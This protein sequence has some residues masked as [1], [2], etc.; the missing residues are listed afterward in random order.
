MRNPP[1]AHK[2]A[3]N[4]CTSYP[5]LFC[6]VDTESFVSSLTPTL[7]IHRFRLGVAI[8]A[9]FR[10]DSSPAHLEILHF[11]D[12][13]AFWD[14]V[15][16]FL[17][18]KNTLHIV[19]HNIHYDMVQ[20]KWRENLSEL[21]FECEFVFQEALTFISKWKKDERR[22]MLINNT[23]WFPGKLSLWGDNLKIE[24]LPMP[25][26][27]ESDEKWFVY[28]ERDAQI[29]YELQ[30]WLCE[31]IVSNNLGNWKYT[32]ASLSFNAYRHRF[33]LHPIY[34][35]HNDEEVKIA[36][37]SYHGGRVE[38]LFAGK[39]PEQVYYK[40]D[41]NSMYPYV[42]SK[43]L[44][45]VNAE[46]MIDKINIR[47]LKTLLKHYGAIA[48]VTLNCS[49]PY[50]P[51]KIEKK[52]CYPI[53]EFTAILSTP[54]LKLCLANGWLKEVHSLVF[55]RMREI[56]TEFVDYF[57]S[58]RMKHKEQNDPLRA[59]M[60]KLY[61]NSLY[62]KFGQAGFYDEIIGKAP[63]NSIEVSYGYDTDNDVRFILKQI[64]QN[65]I[66]SY[67]KGEGYNSFVSIASHVTAYARLFLY[68]LVLT[69]ERKNT[70]YLDTD[71]L[72]V[73]QEGF[74]NLQHLLDEKRLGA[75]KIEGRG[76]ELIIEAPKQYFFNDEW[77]RKGIRKDAVEI[78]PNLYTQ[79]Q[80]PGLNTSLRQA[81]EYYF[82]VIVT[83]QLDNI[84][85]SGII[86]PNGHV[87]PFVLQSKKKKKRGLWKF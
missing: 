71:C 62:G 34:I 47:E 16:S 56:F 3:K 48:N 65:V 53:G 21:G 9:R 79:E 55:Y 5:Q 7:K 75:L 8:F 29:L 19:A 32:L 76:N 63:P 45:P 1:P 67:K 78:A 43:N 23:N 50:F 24:K 59:L 36:R 73:N 81:E 15:N 30:K 80:W 57:Y 83:K 4:K 12:R 6:F 51:Y 87:S 38:C 40:L 25:K 82:N 69:A 77:T 35:S 20:L 85:A 22:I 31:F 49:Q 39:A 42:M 13:K 54:E 74:D 37:E 44:F 66:K 18:G 2:L 61:M 68:D 72:I 27:E 41:V 26:P 33:M 46:G 86:E 70:F 11:T 58:E 14:K 64:G 10:K 52:T 60:F 84:I 28:C 17:R